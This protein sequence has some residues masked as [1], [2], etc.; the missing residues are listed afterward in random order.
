MHIMR[1]HITQPCFSVCIS[2][3]TVGSGA[4]MQIIFITYAL[5]GAF[6]R[7]VL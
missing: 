2:R 6:E 4:W 3:G 1:I 5:G 7:I